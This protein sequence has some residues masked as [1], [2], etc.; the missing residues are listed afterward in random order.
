MHGNLWVIADV[1]LNFLSHLVD[2]FERHGINFFI[3]VHEQKGKD[4]KNLFV[5]IEDSSI[6]IALFSPRYPE[7]KWCM[8]EL[9][10]MKKLVVKKKLIVIPIFYKVQAKDVRNLKGEFGENFYKLAK[11]NPDR[12]TKWK[13]AL[14]CICNKMGMS[15]PDRSSEAD[16]VKEIVK[17]VQ[18]VLEAIRLEEEENLSVCHLGRKTGNIGISAMVSVTLI[19]GILGLLWFMIC[20]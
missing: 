15:L 2:A 19:F 20:S 3:D 1:R 12:I 8:D 7:S 5:R 4:L 11:A 9:V 10:K 13:D 18:R 6:A 16:F 17:E 14:Q